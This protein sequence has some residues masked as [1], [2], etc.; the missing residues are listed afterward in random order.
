MQIPSKKELDQLFQ[1]Y[2]RDS[3]GALDYKEFAAI[4]TGNLGDPNQDTNERKANQYGQGI[5]YRP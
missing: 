3:S 4:L 2:D 1:Y 5:G